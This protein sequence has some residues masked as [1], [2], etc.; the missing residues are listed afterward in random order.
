MSDFSPNTTRAS[1]EVARVALGRMLGAVPNNDERQELPVTMAVRASDAWKAVERVLR[2]L[3]GRGELAGQTLL[4]EARRLDVLDMEGMHALVALREWVER[5]LAP[6]SAAQLLTLAPT[7]AEKEVARNAL[8][9]LERMSGTADRGASQKYAPPGTSSQAPVSAASQASPPSP[10]AP[11]TAASYSPPS[12]ATPPPPVSRDAAPLQPT[13]EGTQWGTLVEPPKTP[14]SKALIIAAVVAIA[15]LVAGGGWYALRGGAGSSSATDQGAAAYARG[16]KEAARLSFVQALEKNPNDVRAL[17][18]LGRI[19]R[20][21]GNL[22]TSRKY[23]ETALR[24]DDKNA[25]AL[26]EFGSALLAD[27]QPE[28]ARRFYVRAVEA[29]PNDRVA[30]GFLGCALM[31]LD[32]T[33][34]ALKWMARAGTG[35]WAT[36]SRSIDTQAAP[37]VAKD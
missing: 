16:S 25:L 5:T 1:V 8:A 9:V 27:Q 13:S 11:P 4:S 28:L 7:D 33:E 32:R 22:A 36:C 10:W 12:R 30:Q 18:Y 3:T 14:R 17:T 23:L 20:E 24:I 15:I 6:G 31:R 19:S 26:R 2:T 29:N 34:E 35:E 37:P 21:L